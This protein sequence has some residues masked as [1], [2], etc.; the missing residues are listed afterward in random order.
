VV[1]FDGGRLPSIDLDVV[2]AFDVVVVVV[3]WPVLGINFGIWKF[4]KAYVEPELRWNI[5]VEIYLLH[6]EVGKFKIINKKLCYK[7]P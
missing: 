3:V 2:P 5:F 6:K 1:T 4:F 7:N